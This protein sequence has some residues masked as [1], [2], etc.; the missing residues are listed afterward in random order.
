[1]ALGAACRL[2]GEMSR[3]EGLSQ[4]WRAG[5]VLVAA[6]V[7]AAAVAA[8]SDDGGGTPAGDTGQDVADAVD[9]DVLDETAGDPTDEEAPDDA[10]DDAGDATSD[11]AGDPGSDASGD[12]EQDGDDEVSDFGIGDQPDDLGTPEYPICPYETASATLDCEVIC[13]AMVACDGEAMAAFCAEFCANAEDLFNQAAGDA[14]E[15]CLTSTSCASV[16][17]EQEL[18][19]YCLI[20]VLGGLAA[21]PAAVAACSALDAA[22]ET[23]TEESSTLGARCEAIA[24]L[25]R[26]EATPLLEECALA[27]CDAILNCVGAAVCDILL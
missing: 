21:N 15:T 6:L 22:F 7:L 24:P 14:F 20:Q 13:G 5:R 11:P 4:G 1:M 16:P 3:S 23:C 9:V 26:S 19:G 27:P 17:E 12:A 8:C 25:L 18:G 10:G 2:E